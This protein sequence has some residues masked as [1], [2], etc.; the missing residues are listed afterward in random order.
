MK[1]NNLLD[2][3]KNIAFAPLA[4]SIALRSFTS[5]DSDGR[6]APRAVT[7]LL[8]LLIL[9]AEFVE[10]PDEFLLVPVVPVSSFYLLPVGHPMGHR[11]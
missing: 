10:P 6:V 9:T 5:T 3:S 7:C 1:S 4:P 2:L 8:F 11:V